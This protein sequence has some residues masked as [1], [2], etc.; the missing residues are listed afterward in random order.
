MLRKTCLF[1][2]LAALILAMMAPAG[3]EP[4]FT[5]ACQ[6]RLTARNALNAKYGLSPALLGYFEEALNQDG[7]GYLVSYYAANEDL[8]YV[9]GRYTVRVNGEQAEAAWS[10]DGKDVPYAGNGLAAHAWGKEQL[11]EIWLINLQTAD[12]RNYALI[13]RAISIEAVKKEGYLSGTPQD[14]E[15]DI[16]AEYDPSLAKLTAEEAQKIALKG[17][18]TA[19][20]LTD[21]QMAGFVVDREDILYE[22]SAETGEPTL[23]VS[24][25]NWDEDGWKEGNG[26]YMVTVNLASGLIEYMY[27]M[28][29]VIG[30]G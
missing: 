2:T 25:I 1:A 10:W 23:V 24:C 26:L 15:P 13:A 8:D 29:G 11:T 7:E 12:M 6:A 3:A 30:N 19:Y 28:D 21:E 17:V 20:G 22:A 9:L 14:D 27:Y 16:P 5:D 4:L 18:Q